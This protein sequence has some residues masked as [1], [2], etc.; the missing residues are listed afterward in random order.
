MY[1]YLAYIGGLFYII[2]YAPQ[3][4]DIWFEHTDRI[5]IPFFFIQLAG[6]IFMILYAYLNSL[7][8]IICLNA[9]AIFFILLIL[10]GIYREKNKN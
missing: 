8:P 10:C 2:C 4:Y 1:D 9:S 7:I 3:I 5:N 6:A